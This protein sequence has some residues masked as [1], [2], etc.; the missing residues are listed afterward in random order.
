ME[1]TSF[2]GKNNKYNATLINVNGHSISN[3]TLIIE[4]TN[5]MNET[6]SFVRESDEN[7]FVEFLF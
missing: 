7:G 6:I 3:Q 1:N 4:I 2:Y 5:E